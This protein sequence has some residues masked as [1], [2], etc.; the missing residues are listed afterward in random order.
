[1]TIKQLK[2]VNTTALN[3]QGTFDIGLRDNLLIKPNSK[4]GLKKF[5]LQQ[6]PV[7]VFGID[8]GLQTFIFNPDTQGGGEDIGRPAVDRPITFGNTGLK[9][10]SLYDLAKAL[11]TA[12]KITLTCGELKED[13][14]RYVVQTA[15]KPT[16]D[17]G[18]DVYFN[19]NA[20]TGTMEFTFNSYALTDVTKNS[21]E[22]SN[23]STKNSGRGFAVRNMTYAFYMKG[24]SNTRLIDGAFQC[25][26]QITQIGR[27][28][29]DY[30]IGLCDPKVAPP[31]IHTP[32]IMDFG[33]TKSNNSQWAIKDG[34]TNT[35]I[36]YQWEAGDYIVFFTN[37][38]QLN[39]GIYPLDTSVPDTPDAFRAGNTTKYAY[40]FKNYTVNSG[41]E[42]V[43]IITS[44][45][46][47]AE[48][49]VP[50]DRPLF[51][52]FKSTSTIDPKSLLYT[53]PNGVK[54]TV[55]LDFSG[56]KQ[57]SNQLGFSSS[58]L[59]TPY[60][61]SSLFTGSKDPNFNKLLDLGLF[62]SLPTQT[63]VA[64]GDKTRNSKENMI[65]SF[66]PQRQTALSDTLYYDEEITYVDIGNY[67]EMNISSLSFRVV[68]EFP[69]VLNNIPETDYISFVLYIKDE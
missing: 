5:L 23:T 32:D 51:S 9:F 4:V 38:G 36:E 1:M 6:K 43:P 44:T 67:S 11:E 45:V 59:L 16:N 21:W 12:I 57:L 8:I 65:A 15:S 22:E 28:N 10:G 2:V 19:V 55:K 34:A 47:T 58:T 39:L 29:Y 40:T 50:A 18:L 68:N 13:I 42:Y 56:A 7:E 52:Q 33:L 14:K 26:T 63:Y 49:T 35:L 60:T 62:W 53:S 48:A 30:I 24:S 46:F 27:N 69:N 31:N 66:T 64:T 61:N 3:A 17:A 41:K 25:Y 54:R 37:Q 20:E